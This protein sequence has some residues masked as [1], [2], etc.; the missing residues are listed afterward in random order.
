[1][2]GG[3]GTMLLK[4]MPPLHLLALVILTRKRRRKGKK[5][6]FS[7]NA[8][9]VATQLSGRD[10]LSNRGRQIEEGGRG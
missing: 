5:R 2:N 10:F 1:M 4:P 7:Q 3:Q 9:D 8:I 6:Q